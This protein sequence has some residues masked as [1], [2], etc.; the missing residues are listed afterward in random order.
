MY[1][2]M[3]NSSFSECYTMSPYWYCQEALQNSNATQEHNMMYGLPMPQYTYSQS[4]IVD[5]PVCSSS[6]TTTS[7]ELTY[8]A[9]AANVIHINEQRPRQSNMCDPR[10]KPVHPKPPYSYI[11]LICMAIA[12]T[13]E[14]KA[15][16]REIIKYI[17]NNFPYYRSNKKWH[18]SIR[19]N[20][21]IN[22][23]FVKLPRRPGVKSCLWTV[24][25]AFKDMFDNGSLRRRR[26][27]FKEGTESWNK[28]K[29]NTV[30]KRMSHKKP[31]DSLP[32]S[33]HQTY[34][35]VSTLDVSP[36]NNYQEQRYMQMVHTEQTPSDAS[37]NSATSLSSS[38][39]ELDEILCTFN[40]YD[41]MTPILST[42][43]T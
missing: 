13:L 32:I 29:V 31:H 20:L 11:S 35:L 26:Y 24:D 12:D 38:L 33:R 5:N 40:T 42:F 22:D 18:G 39:E 4:Q 23:C 3:P 6:V 16:L 14:K 9:N 34:D 15:T 30:A 43:S 17:E 10:R 37:P 19:H 7:C 1:S 41:N 8:A 36:T 28:S 27:R 2:A 25:P 21:T